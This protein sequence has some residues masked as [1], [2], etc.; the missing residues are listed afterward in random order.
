ML[1]KTLMVPPLWCIVIVCMFF[2]MAR[3]DT[4]E[5][6]LKVALNTITLTLFLMVVDCKSDPQLDQTKE[7]QRIENWY[8]L[9]LLKHAILRRP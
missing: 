6:L 4:T 9:H 8:L 3:H 5:I 2:L 1:F 7:L